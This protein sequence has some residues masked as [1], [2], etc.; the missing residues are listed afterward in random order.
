MSLLAAEFL[1][2]EQSLTGIV[3][4]APAISA[5][6]SCAAA[7]QRSERGIW[8][9][10]SAGDV[11]FLGLG[12]VLFGTFDGVHRPASGCIGFAHRP[13]PGPAGHCQLRQIPYRLGMIAQFN[14]GGHFGCV[15]RVFAAET[16]API[17]RDRTSA[18]PGT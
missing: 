17:L 15:H 3:L 11:W 18:M 12:T 16:I 10:Y 13:A 4:L 6:W 14:L 8:N 1:S 2:A 5:R 9:F 7:M